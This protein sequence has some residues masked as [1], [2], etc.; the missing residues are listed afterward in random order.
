MPL[1]SDK[2]SVC[3][4]VECKSRCLWPLC[5]WLSRLGDLSASEAQIGCHMWFPPLW[6]H[7]WK[8]I[9]LKGVLVGFSS[10]GQQMHEFLIEREHRN[11]IN[12]IHYWQNKLAN[13]AS[14][15]SLPQ[16]QAFNTPIH[17]LFY[18]H[19][20]LILIPN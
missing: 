10:I 15:S 11:N 18:P 3:C 20:T 19:L 2:S 14:K 7:H 17:E 9:E 13:L 16:A 4:R 12:R 6:T 5:F 8:E 1:L